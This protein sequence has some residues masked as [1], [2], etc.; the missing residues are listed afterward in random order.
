MALALMLAAP[1]AQ[2]Q[3]YFQSVPAN[4]AWQQKVYEKV[5][6]AWVAPA[7]KDSPKPGQKTVVQVV[8][9]GKGAIVSTLVSMESGAAKFDAAALAAVKRAAPY[10]APLSSPAEFHVHVTWA[11]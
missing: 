1:H 10:P 3:L 11:P 9:D 8:V 7:A 4:P 5:S 2:L 6:R